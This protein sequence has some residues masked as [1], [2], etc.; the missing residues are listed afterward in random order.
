MWWCEKSSYTLLCALSH[1][2][3]L[4]AGTNTVQVQVVLCKY[5][6]ILSWIGFIC[7]SFVYYLQELNIYRE[8]RGKTPRTEAMLEDV[9]DANENESEYSEGFLLLKI[10]SK[11]FIYLSSIRIGVWRWRTWPTRGFARFRSKGEEEIA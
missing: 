4:T 5:Q 3:S 10:V 2:H 11:K 8:M 9:S 7:Q 1:S 6:I